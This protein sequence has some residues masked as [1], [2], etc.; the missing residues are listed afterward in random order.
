MIYA[1]TAPTG[2]A[3]ALGPVPAGRLRE[4]RGT[5]TGRIAAPGQRQPWH[6]HRTRTGWSPWP[7]PTTASTRSPG[8][9]RAW[10]H[11]SV[12]GVVYGIPE[13]STCSPTTGTR[14]TA[15]GWWSSST[16]GRTLRLGEPEGE[17]LHPPVV[18]DQVGG[19]HHLGVEARLAD[20]VRRWPMSPELPKKISIRPVGQS[21]APAP[22]GR[23]ASSPR[24]SRRCSPSPAGP[25]VRTSGT[26]GRRRSGRSGRRRRR[27]HRRGDPDPVGDAVAGRVR[28][29][30]G[31]RLGVDVHRHSS[32]ETAA[33]R[34]A[35][36]PQPVPMSR[37]RSPG[38][39]SAST[40]SPS[41]C[42]VP[43]IGCTR[44]GTTR[45]RPR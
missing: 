3:V 11:E 43:L 13:R 15:A 14:R 35:L 23:S 9:S 1:S 25:A 19:G 10:W 26:A 21:G 32:V 5:G 31:D 20:Q 18:L 34:M 42:E 4:R 24:S 33:A 8:A 38:R 28:L 27:R 12:G 7:R 45:V 2:S 30:R 6:D 17:V 44:G 39:T 37:T 29:R 16:S 40:A 22:G 36:T 41:R